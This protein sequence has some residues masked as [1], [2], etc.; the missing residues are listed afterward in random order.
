MAEFNGSEG[1]IPGPISGIAPSAPAQLTRADA[2]R[3][4]KEEG[5]DII[6]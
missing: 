2:I 5:A 4:A 3:I 6:D 1:F